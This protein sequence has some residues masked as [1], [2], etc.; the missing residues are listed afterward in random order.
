MLCS[1]GWELHEVGIAG[2]PMNQSPS[3][4]NH[5]NNQKAP[6]LES[7]SLITP[8]FFTEIVKKN[9][10][11]LNRLH[12]VCTSK[13]STTKLR[14]RFKQM[15]KVLSLAILQWLKACYN[16]NNNSGTPRNPAFVFQCTE[17]RLAGCL[18]Y[19]NFFLPFTNSPRENMYSLNTLI[20]S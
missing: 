6:M 9:Y 8:F 18:A 19:H 7:R 20:F 2:E 5:K 16:F 15:A 13:Q 4:S 11:R 10:K 14:Y 12:F 17:F 1:S 3:P